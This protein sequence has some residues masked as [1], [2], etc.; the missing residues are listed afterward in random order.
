[1]TGRPASR[2]AVRSIGASER[3]SIGGAGRAP[4]PRPSRPCAQV[5]ELEFVN[6]GGTGS[7]ESTHADASVTEVA[8]GSGPVRPSP[9]RRLLAASARRRPRPSPC[10]WCAGPRRTRPR[11]SAAAGSPPVPPAADRLPAARS[12][13]RACAAGRWRWRARCRPRSPAR[14]AARL[15]VGDRVWLRHTKSGELSEHVNELRARARRPRSSTCCPPT[16]AKERPFC[17]RQRGLWRNWARTEAVRPRRVERPGSVGAVQRAVIAAGKRGPADQGG[18]RRP[19]LHRDRRGARRAARPV[20]PRRGL[21]AWMPPRRQATLAA[22]TPP[23]PPAARCSSRTGWRCRTWATSTA[24]TIAGAT[25]TGTHG[26]GGRFGRPG[27][28]RSWPSPWSPATARCCESASSE[29]A[30]LLP[31]AALGL[32]ALGILVDVT[33]QCVPAFLL[34]AVEN[35]RAAR[36]RARGV[37]G[38]HRGRRP[39][40]V[41]LVPAHRD[42]ADEDQHPAAGGVRPR[43]RSAGCPRWVDDELLANGAFRGTCALGSARPVARSRGSTGWPSGSARRPR[44]HRRLRPGVRDQPHACASGRWSTRSRARRSRSRCARCARLID[45]QRLADLLPDRGAR[46]RRR[47]HLAL[48]R[49]RR[50]RRATSPSTGTSARTTPSTS[51]RSRRSCARHGGRPHWGKIHYQDAESLRGLYPRFDDFLAVRDRLDP[52]RR[53]T[54]PYLER[55]LGS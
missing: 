10:R 20:R 1:M 6:G 54:N 26:T 33:L 7:L 48:H 15:A 52:E 29:N 50:E 11:C 55:V 14:S 4:R 3:R 32:G 39:L 45:E 49:A 30:E 24:Q 47:R 34:H 18:R 13:R 22:G 51:G 19:Q 2:C 9:L 5:A 12:G 28:A 46:R 35:R 41:L 17:E 25:S 42:G 37:C 36:R 44:V 8:A 53:F 16:G 21:P 31:A 38:A 43:G 40:R 27:R 23:A